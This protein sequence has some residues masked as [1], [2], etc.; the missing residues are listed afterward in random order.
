M[1]GFSLMI[2]GVIDF[3]HLWVWAS[4]YRDCPIVEWRF[5]LYSLEFLWTDSPTGDTDL[6]NHE[7]K[8][9]SIC[10]EVEPDIRISIVQ[11]QYYYCPEIQ[12]HCPGMKESRSPEIMALVRPIA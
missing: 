8:L 6:S 1:I 3:L 9:L 4:V 2:V 12:S 5:V 10:D 7:P 11:D